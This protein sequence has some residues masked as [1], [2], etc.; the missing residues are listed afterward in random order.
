MNIMASDW[1]TLASV[2]PLI[3]HYTH[4]CVLRMVESND[5][6]GPRRNSLLLQQQNSNK[7][8]PQPQQQQQQRQP[9][10]PV[11]AKQQ[12]QKYH[13]HQHQQQQQQQH[14][15]E[16]AQA[17]SPFSIWTSKPLVTIASLMVRYW[18]LI[19]QTW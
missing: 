2:W 10:K 5:E 11:Q 12:Q 7:R 18:P 15:Q 1:S 4:G 19:G 8:Q 13:Q 3:G 14:Y 17:A 9:Q 16:E 6:A